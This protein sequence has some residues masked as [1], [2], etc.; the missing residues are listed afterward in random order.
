MFLSCQVLTK[1]L[2]AAISVLSGTVISLANCPRSQGIG[3]GVAVGG[4]GVL[5]GSGVFVG[6]KGV[7]V[8]RMTTGEVGVAASPPV[9]ALGR[10]I[11]VPSAA[12]VC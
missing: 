7:L 6:G 11:G 1:V 5:V 10:R 9:V 3:M 8:G 2:P 12:W 4:T